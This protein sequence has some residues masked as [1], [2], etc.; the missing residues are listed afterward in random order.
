MRL[1]YVVVTSMLLQ[2]QAAFG[3]HATLIEEAPPTTASSRQSMR[4][5]SKK[6]S[7]VIQKQ[8]LRSLFKGGEYHSIEAMRMDRRLGVGVETFGRLGM[9]GFDTEINLMADDSATAGLGGGPGYNALSLGWK[10]IFGGARLAPYAG[11]SLAHWASTGK[12][13][14]EGTMPGFLEDKFLTDREISSGHFSKNFLIPS[15]GL[16]MTQL[17][18]P[19]AGGALFAEVLFLF[20][21]STMDQVPTGAL[22][23]LYYF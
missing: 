4:E 16:Q 22:G 19:S 21:A 10:H 8:S 6:G 15:L 11:F 2:A 9:I 17:S 12:G 7:Y 1:L 13:K 20:D 14:I 18:G 23:A 3:Q 5:E